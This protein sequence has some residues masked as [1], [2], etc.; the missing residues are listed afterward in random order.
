MMSFMKKKPI[1]KP[2]RP[3]VIEL[4]AE[5][6]QRFAELA[7]A[8]LGPTKSMLE[9]SRLPEFEEPSSVPLGQPK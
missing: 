1:N 6:Q 3:E 9:L 4:S 7:K 8:P 5:G 2:A